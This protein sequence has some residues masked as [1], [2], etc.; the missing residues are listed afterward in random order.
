MTCTK[1]T[2]VPRISVPAMRPQVSPY[3]SPYRGGE[4]WLIVLFRGR[5][6]FRGWWVMVL[7]G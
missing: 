2:P 4:G 7:P 1:E 6:K 5:E 3:I